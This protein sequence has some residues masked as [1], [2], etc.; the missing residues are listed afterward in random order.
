LR[1]SDPDEN[2]KRALQVLFGQASRPV[3]VTAAPRCIVRG[4]LDTNPEKQVGAV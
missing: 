3:I 2:K 1:R 4:L